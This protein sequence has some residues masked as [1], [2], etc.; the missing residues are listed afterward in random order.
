MGALSDA[1]KN[2]LLDGL[3]RNVSYQNAAVWAKLHTGAP[4]AAGTANAST[5]ATRKQ[6]TFGSAAASRTISNTALVEWTGVSTTETHTHVSL[7]SASSGGT[8]LGSDALPSS[9]GS[10]A[11]ENVRIAIGAVSLSI[12]GTDIS[13]AIAN[14]MLDAVCR[15]VAFAVAAV[16]LKLHL[17]DPGSAGTSN[18]AAHTTRVQATFGAAA[19]SGAIANTAAVSFASLSATEAITHVSAWSASSAGTFLF[20][21]AAS[22]SAS[23]QAGDTWELPIGDLDVT[24]SGAVP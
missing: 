16:H 10:Q 8:F 6:V 4:G 9:V 12:G 7:W 20:R 21:K 11:G 2:S 24:L 17:G 18:P 23:V 22:A 13:D 19:A 1:V 5:E 3:C 14:A 15:N